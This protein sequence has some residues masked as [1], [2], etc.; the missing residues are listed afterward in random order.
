MA[1]SNVNT[2]W[3]LQLQTG[4]VGLY[5]WP[6]PSSGSLAYSILGRG[7]SLQ[8]DRSHLAHTQ[9]PVWS[10]PADHMANN[11]KLAAC[12]RLAHVVAPGRCTCPLLSQQAA[13]LA[14]WMCSSSQ[15][16]WSPSPQVTGMRTSQALNS[17]LQ[18]SQSKW[19]SQP[20]GNPYG[21]SRQQPMTSDLTYLA[22]PVSSPGSPVEASMTSH[23][24]MAEAD[25][26]L[27]P[28]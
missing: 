17:P 16:P 6:C 2:A 21:C 3:V 15:G 18:H 11:K 1:P 25:L 13:Q 14:D 23:T 10:Y 22:D 24:S 20:T 19:V 8:A 28:V 27:R 9:C 5:S 4:H 26:T 12:R 7:C